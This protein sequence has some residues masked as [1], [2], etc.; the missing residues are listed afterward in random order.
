MRIVTDFPNL[1][2]CCVYWFFYSPVEA[3]N[4]FQKTSWSVYIHLVKKAL[5]KMAVASR[6][7][8][9]IRKAICSSHAALE[10]QVNVTGK[11]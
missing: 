11:V 7:L 4:S 5:E 2:Y 9:G 10:N 1:S 8:D 3:T 6:L